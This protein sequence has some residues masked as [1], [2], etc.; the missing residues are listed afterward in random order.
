[1]G[2]YLFF[3]ILISG[4][5]ITSSCDDEYNFATDNLATNNEV[6]TELAVPIIDASFSLEDY[7]PKD[8]NSYFLVDDEHFMTLVFEYLLKEVPAPDFFSGV[9][10]GTLASITY[11]IPEQSFKL[12][13]DRAVSNDEFYIKDPLISITITNFWDIP[14]QFQLVNFKYYNAANPLGLP[15]TGSF[16]SAWHDIK[17]PVS[18]ALYADTVYFMDNSNSNLDEVISAMPTH[19]TSAAVIQTNPG[20]PYNV[21]STTTDTVRMKIELPLDIRIGN[22]VML[23][24]LDFKGGKDLAGDTSK[25]ESMFMNLVFENGFPIDINALIILADSN[26][27]HL[28]TILTEPEKEPITI[29]SGIVSAGKVIAPNKFTMMNIEADKGVIVNTAYLLTNFTFDTYNNQLG[30]TVKIYSDYAI[31]FKVGVRIK[32]KI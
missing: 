13:N 17:R 27:N 1:M 9:Y 22:L 5:L 4:F 30:E 21:S 6:N 10:S 18:P 14:A 16:V 20:S 19:L 11:D 31:G 25:F 26:Y 24:T 7:I 15:I 2:K 32:L 3:F 12:G 29:P 8:S 23:D 28:D